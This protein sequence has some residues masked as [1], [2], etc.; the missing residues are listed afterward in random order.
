MKKDKCIYD[1]EEFFG[2]PIIETRNMASVYFE[3]QPM[4]FLDEDGVVWMAHHTEEGWKRSRSNH[5][6]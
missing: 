5:W 4:G 6:G 2:L 3:D 1:K